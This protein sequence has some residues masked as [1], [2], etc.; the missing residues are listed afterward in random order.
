MGELWDGIITKPLSC[1]GGMSL[2]DDM[3]PLRAYGGCQIRAGAALPEISAP[4]R[5]V[6]NPPENNCPPLPKTKKT[7][8]LAFLKAA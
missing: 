2:A 1:K 8:A 6:F 4:T 3:T 7:F 5:D